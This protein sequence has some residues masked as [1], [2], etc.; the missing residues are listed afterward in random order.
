MFN[1]IYDAAQ[2]IIRLIMKSP[3]FYRIRHMGVCH[4]LLNTLN[5][6]IF[7]GRIGGRVVRYLDYRAGV[8]TPVVPRCFIASHLYSHRKSVCYLENA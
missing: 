7:L 1:I 4:F 8:Q 2:L 6:D 5:Y 3:A